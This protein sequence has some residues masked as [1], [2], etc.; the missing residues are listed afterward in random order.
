M[1]KK[2]TSLFLI[3]LITF[4]LITPS[5]IF[6]Y[7][8]SDT[9]TM[10]NGNVI[11]L[12]HP[13][14]FDDTNL[15]TYFPLRSF[16]EKN[17]YKIIY[18]APKKTIYG[19]NGIT[20]FSVTIGSDS[21]TVNN[22]IYT[23]SYSPSKVI[24][25]TAYISEFTVSR[26]MNSSVVYYKDENIIELIKDNSVSDYDFNTSRYIPD[27]KISNLTF[28]LIANLKDFDSESV[29]DAKE[30]IFN[31]YSSKDY[32]YLAKNKEN[33]NSEVVEKCQN[34][35]EEYAKKVTDIFKRNDRLIYSETSTKNHIDFTMKLLYFIPDE[36]VIELFASISQ[37]SSVL[38][39]KTFAEAKEIYFDIFSFFIDDYINSYDI[40]NSEISEEI[41]TKITEM[42]GKIKT[43]ASGHNIKLLNYS[44]YA[45]SLKDIFETIKPLQKELPANLRFTDEFPEKP[46]A[47]IFNNN[48][49]SQEELD[50]LTNQMKIYLENF[51]KNALAEEEN[52]ILDKSRYTVA[53]RE[54]S[55][56]YM[57]TKEALDGK[58][59]PAEY[60]Q[61]MSEISEYVK[62]LLLNG[63]RLNTQEKIDT[64]TEKLEK[65]IEKLKKIE[66]VL[67]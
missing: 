40:N 2:L 12:N 49:T 23:D 65:Y 33:K 10:V 26:I 46:Y 29:N 31:Y 62:V 39:N 51:N 44:E 54:L 43:F 27:G 15:E 14:F 5:K 37:L 38:N 25:N 53:E 32:A 9:I 3:T 63:Q 21:F 67:K 1:K 41:K 52:P 34:I 7:F 56:I 6:A 66:E 13:V 64:A 19:T 61:L 24:N 55:N 50:K 60:T 45:K 47:I 48:F 36:N 28:K 57:Q 35:R 20:D 42:T 11:E 22:E 30:L 8:D 58:T 18:D 17:G 4:S 16:L 59:A